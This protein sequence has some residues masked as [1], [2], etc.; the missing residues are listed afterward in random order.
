MKTISSIIFLIFLIFSLTL[1]ISTGTKLRNKNLKRFRN[2][3]TCTKCAQPGDDCILDS[4]CQGK[5]CGSRCLCEFFI[6]V[7]Y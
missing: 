6:C 3:G 7:K 5:Q 2:W 1:S 4:N